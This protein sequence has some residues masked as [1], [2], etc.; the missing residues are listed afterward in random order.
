M[1]KITGTTAGYVLFQAAMNYPTTQDFVI[2]LDSAS[3]N[4]TAVAIVVAGQK[5]VLK[6][7]WT[8]VATATWYRTTK[9]TVIILSNATA[10]RYQN[11]KYTF[12]GTGTGV[13]K[14]TNS[15][16]KLWLE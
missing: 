16:L 3:G 11:F 6:N 2:R 12:T 13:T 4:H 7:D 10:S 14:L 8:T 1:Y 15:Y 5:S 9:D